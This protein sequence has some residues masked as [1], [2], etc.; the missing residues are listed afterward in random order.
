MVLAPSV[1]CS[2]GKAT[3][4]TVLSMNAMLEPR[5][6]A[7]ST[8]RS[9]PSTTRGSGGDWLPTPLEHSLPEANGK[10]VD[11][12]HAA[13]AAF[14]PARPVSCSGGGRCSGSR[15]GRLV[16]RTRVYPGPLNGAVCGG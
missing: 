9:V 8:Q 12:P 6:L 10:V 4:T 7:R 14:E 1:R 2:T 16:H 13:I 3:F 11:S 5:M 15:A